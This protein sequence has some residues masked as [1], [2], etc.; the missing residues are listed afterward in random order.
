MSPIDDRPKNCRLTLGAWDSYKTNCVRGRLFFTLGDSWLSWINRTY[1]RRFLGKSRLELT[2]SHVGIVGDERFAYESLVR[3]GPTRDFSIDRYTCGPSNRLII[4]DL[5][6]PLSDIAITAGIQSM[7]RYM[8]E[9]RHKYDWLS[10]LSLGHFQMNNALICSEMAQIYI[11]EV[12]RA[13]PGYQFPV[14]QLVLPLYIL[15]LV[16]FPYAFDA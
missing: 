14:D 4:A 15:S 9:R 5:D 7:L 1:Q 2:P 8:R 6:L 3:R 12:Y 11:N 13:T 10:L 16:K